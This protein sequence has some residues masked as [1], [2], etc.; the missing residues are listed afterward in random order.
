MVQEFEAVGLD[1]WFRYLGRLSTFNVP[2]FRL[3]WGCERAVRWHTAIKFR[4]CDALIAAF[5]SSRDA[6][7]RKLRP[8]FCVP[9]VA[10]RR[11]PA[12]HFCGDRLGAAL[13]VAM[14]ATRLP[15][16]R[17]RT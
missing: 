6:D 9:I 3:D 13:R 10:G 14:R 2:E 8:P 7:D 11:Q 16:M 15:R 4:G 1:Q 12:C 5:V 17:H